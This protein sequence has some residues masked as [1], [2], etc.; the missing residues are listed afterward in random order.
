MNQLIPD[1]WQDI[2]ADETASPSFRQLTAFLKNEWKNEEIFPPVDKIFTALR[3]VPYS[4]IKV[5]ILGQDPYHDDNQAHGLA[6]SVPDGVKLPP[7]L[8]N[9]YK[10]LESDLGILPSAN[11]NLESW[12]KQGVLLLNTVLTVRA[13]NPNSHAGRGWEEFTD[14]ILRKI[15]EKSTPVVFLLWGGKA[16]K[17]LPLIDQERH[18]VI[19]TAHPSPLSAY[20]GFFGSKPFSGINAFLEADGISPVD[21]RI[22]DSN[23]N[24]PLFSF[25]EG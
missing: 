5:V 19:M 16:A 18:H 4:D 2:L 1:G 9:I 15:S 8:R 3:L 25:S 20:R 10:E 11:G 13:H 7:S 17:K 24:M 6:F 21:W 12:A 14:S 22:P 23:N